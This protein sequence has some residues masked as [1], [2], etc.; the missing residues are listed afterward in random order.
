MRIIKKFDPYDP[1]RFNR[2][3]GHK[4]TIWPIGR[5]PEIDWGLWI[6]SSDKGGFVEIDAEPGDIVRAGQKD[7]EGFDTSSGWFIVERD[8]ALTP[9]NITEAR[10]HYY[11][12]EEAKTTKT[13]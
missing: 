9:T 13:K 6:G 1:K 4:I 11:K 3:W 8:G 2:P 10:E 7:L 12:R 5:E